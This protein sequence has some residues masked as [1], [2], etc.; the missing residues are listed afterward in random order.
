[1]FNKMVISSIMLSLFI[2]LYISLRHSNMGG[3]DAE[4]GWD[5]G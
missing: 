4:S 5:D 1:M 2:F 3:G